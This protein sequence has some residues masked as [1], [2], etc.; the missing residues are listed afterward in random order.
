MCDARS[1]KHQ[2]EKYRRA[3]QAI[4]DIIRRMPTVIWRTKAA[5]IHLEHVTLIAISL[6]LWL[7][8]NASML[9]YT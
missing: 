8:E 5:D 9:R 7:R 3:G 2:M 4:D 6:Q 1:R